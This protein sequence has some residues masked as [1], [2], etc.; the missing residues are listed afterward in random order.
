MIG[1]QQGRS[2]ARYV[3]HGEEAG[4][5]HSNS[6]VSNR[7]AMKMALMFDFPELDV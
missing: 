2:V 6:F 4:E 3:S 5:G 7:L 1:N